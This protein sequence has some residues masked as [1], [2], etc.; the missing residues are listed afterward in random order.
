MVAL[1]ILGIGI[2]TVVEL[3]ASSLRLAAKA[4]RRTQAAIYAQSVMGRLFTQTEL[5]D[6]E[7]SGELPGGYLWRAR[8]QEVRPDEDSSRFQPNRQNPTDFLHL[9]EI[10]VS[11]S[12]E[13][14][15]NSQGLVLH[16]LRTVTEQPAQ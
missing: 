15:G 12:W 3:F 9:K 5:N 1:A 11:V 6:G 2:V 13:E 10:A 16:S 14:N 4:S 7:E 8:V